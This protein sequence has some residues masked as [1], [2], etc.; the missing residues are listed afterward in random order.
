MAAR[1]M[2]PERRKSPRLAES[3][4]LAVSQNGT[5]VHGETNNL[6]ATGVYC[7]LKQ[8]IAPM[9]KLKIEF[10]LPQGT[11]HVRVRCTGIVVRVEPMIADAGS[12]TVAM[13]ENV[14]RPPDEAVASMGSAVMET[15][16]AGA[17]P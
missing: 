13:T 3:L 16:S 9:T 12:V 5:A 17:Q 11:R 1:V 6:S 10:E 14:T 2:Q 4:A 15:A 8:F 7:T